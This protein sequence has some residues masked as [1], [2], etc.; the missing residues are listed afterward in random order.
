MLSYTLRDSLAFLNCLKVFQ[1]CVNAKLRLGCIPRF[2]TAVSLET[3]CIS[4]GPG[5]REWT[6]FSRSLLKAVVSRKLNFETYFLSPSFY[7]ICSSILSMQNIHAVKCKNNQCKNNSWHLLS[8]FLSRRI[9]LCFRAQLGPFLP[10]LL[11]I[12][13]NPPKLCIGNPQMWQ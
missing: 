11:F 2:Q 5:I 1:F 9:L 6:Y 13:N 3:A 4:T 8:R 12:Y 7:V 10:L